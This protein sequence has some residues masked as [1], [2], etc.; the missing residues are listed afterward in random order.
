MHLA[1]SENLEVKRHNS[2]RECVNWIKLSLV[3]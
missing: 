2:E 1:D 3:S